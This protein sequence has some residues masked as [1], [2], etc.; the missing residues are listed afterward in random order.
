MQPGKQ[1]LALLDRKQASSNTLLRKASRRKYNIDMRYMSRNRETHIG[2]ESAFGS[3]AR[4]KLRC[5]SSNCNRPQKIKVCLLV[6]AEPFNH[7]R[8]QL[9][10]ARLIHESTANCACVRC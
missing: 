5:E 1:R 8:K 2:G 6:Q 4:E 7:G 3:H 9:N 10:L